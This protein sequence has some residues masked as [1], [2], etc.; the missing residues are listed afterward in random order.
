MLKTVEGVL[1]KK[2]RVPLFQSFKMSKKKDKKNK[3]VVSK[4]NKP[5]RGIKKDKDICYYCGKEE[6]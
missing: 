2:S 6:Y 1:K 4:V 3:S 5:I